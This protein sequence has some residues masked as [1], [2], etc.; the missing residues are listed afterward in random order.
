[1]HSE[2]SVLALVKI[3]SIAA[4]ITGGAQ[5]GFVSEEGRTDVVDVYPEEGPLPSGSHS[6]KRVKNSRQLRVR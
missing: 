5:N 3:S 2:S 6:L 1:M 4:G